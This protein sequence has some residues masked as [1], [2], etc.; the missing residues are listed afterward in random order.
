MAVIPTYYESPY[1]NVG[2]SYL[3]ISTWEGN[4]NKFFSERLHIFINHKNQHFI[5]GEKTQY[6]NKEEIKITFDE[7]I[8]YDLEIAKNFLLYDIIIPLFESSINMLNFEEIENFK[9]VD[10]RCL[11][12]LNYKFPQ[13]TMDISNLTKNEKIKHYISL[14]KM[15]NIDTSAIY[16]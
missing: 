15:T 9:I 2:K 12:F 16:L 3:I 10:Q 6:N 14:I 7:F 5:K 4:N 1:T 13:L 11:F 8:A